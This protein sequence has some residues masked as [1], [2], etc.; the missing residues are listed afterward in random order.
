MPYETGVIKC[1]LRLPSTTLGNRMFPPVFSHLQW[2]IQGRGEFVRDTRPS[3]YQKCI[4]FMQ[5]SET[6][7]Q[8]IGCRSPRLAPPRPGKWIWKPSVS[9]SDLFHQNLQILQIPDTVIYIV[10]VF[11]SGAA[12]NTNLPRC[13][14]LWT[15]INF[16]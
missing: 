3:L 11:L 9:V 8:I 5:F 2:R 13:Q 12:P 6:I 15:T 10:Y 14:R 7:S 1:I 4:I 16:L